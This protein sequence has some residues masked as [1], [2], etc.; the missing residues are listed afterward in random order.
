[1]EEKTM[2]MSKFILPIFVFVAACLPASVQAATLSLSPQSASYTVGSL[3]AV[4]IYASSPD[5]AMN[6]VSGVV[7]FPKDKLD[8][9]SLSKDESVINLWV[10]DP[11]VS[12]TLGQVN[13]EGVVLNPGFIGSSGKILKIIFRIK[14]SGDALIQFAS[15]SILAN[16]GVGTNILTGFG[17]A[18]FSLVPNSSYETTTATS[19]LETPLIGQD[20]SP[21]ETSTTPA[22][23]VRQTEPFRMIF[24]T[25]DILALLI[26]ISTLIIGF[27]L[28]WLYGLRRIRSARRR[29]KGETREAHAVFQKSYESLKSAIW[30]H[31]SVLAKKHN[32]TKYDLDTVSSL[33]RLGERLDT[34]E[35][36]IQKELH[37][38]EDDLK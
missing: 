7:S 36:S 10:R 29:L 23:N 15:G 16:D 28:L 22:I 37:K 31:L 19:T 24:S 1:M 27:I 4:S 18:S 13:F 8:V 6:A 38:V 25:M 17:K 35:E 20:I 30:E 11:S 14:T 5:Q 3:M 2:K 21:N 34:A 33:Q 9:V 12:A 32:K 26:S